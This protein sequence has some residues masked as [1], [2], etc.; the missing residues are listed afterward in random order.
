[1]S[2]ADTA[3]S[4]F[5]QNPA[6]LV[7]KSMEY[8]RR[9]V[10]ACAFLCKT[11]WMTKNADFEKHWQI[12]VKFGK[13]VALC[14]SF[15]WC[16]GKSV[17]FINLIKRDARKKVTA[18]SQPREMPKD[19]KDE[20]EVLR[21]MLVGIAA[22]SAT[23]SW[24]IL[25][26]HWT[27]RRRNLRWSEIW[28]RK[29]Y[30][31]ACNVWFRHTGL[32]CKTASEYHRSLYTSCNEAKPNFH[33]HSTMWKSELTA[34]RRRASLLF[35]FK[36]IAD[37]YIGRLNLFRVK[38]GNRRFQKAFIT[39]KKIQWKKLV[40]CMLI[41]GKN[42]SKWM[43]PFRWYGVGKTVQHF[44]YHC[45][46]TV[47]ERSKHRYSQINL[48]ESVL[49]MAIQPGKGKGDEELSAALSK[50]QKK[51]LPSR[52]KWTKKQNRHWFMVSANSSWMLCG[53]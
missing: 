14:D 25:Q 37:P 48:P 30:H 15:Q 2:V 41:R 38:T 20:V 33:M 47:F 22:E 21:S 6:K 44:H 29:S 45:G 50:I 40:T 13:S 53:Q 43:N 8:T 36:T 31:R 27:D 4:W 7:L 17:G 18:N 5:P 19:K 9:N 49:C 42:R 28:Y 1:M 32:W 16:D 10:S 46:Y 23:N 11:R 34:H 12:C 39:K 3:W 24:K 35:V 52:W 26:R 51:I